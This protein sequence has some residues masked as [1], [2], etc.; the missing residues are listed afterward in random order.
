MSDRYEERRRDMEP[1]VRERVKQEEV[2]RLIGIRM[3]RFAARLT[4]LAKASH[5]QTDVEL[6]VLSAY[7][8]AAADVIALYHEASV[9]CAIQGGTDGGA[10][11]AER[12]FE[13][14]LAKCHGKT[15]R[16]D[17]KIDADEMK[18]PPPSPN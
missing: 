3:H 13:Q 14:L 4:V 12:Y 16:S 11:R 9:A 5:P 8:H 6:A 18:P 17:M 7:A 2:L 10:A 15:I 1:Q